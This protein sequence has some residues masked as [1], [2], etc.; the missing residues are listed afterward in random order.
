MNLKKSNKTT[1]F[2]FKKHQANKII[3]KGSDRS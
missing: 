2:N 3:I 1:K